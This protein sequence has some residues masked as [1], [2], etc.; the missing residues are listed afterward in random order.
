MRPRSTQSSPRRSLPWIGLTL[1]F[2]FAFYGLVKKT[3][4]LGSL[5]GLTLETGILI[6]P[7]ATYLLLAG[8]TLHMVVVKTNPG[9]DSNPGHAGTGTVVSQIC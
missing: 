4:P 9:Y 8:N 3:A 7:A 6:V 2:A 5:H 1:A